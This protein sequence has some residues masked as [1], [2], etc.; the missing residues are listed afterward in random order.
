M[1]LTTSITSAGLTA[2]TPSE[3][4]ADILARAQALSSGLTAN[5]PASLIEDVLATVTGACSIL[6]Q[7]RQDV[8]ASV[9][10]YSV[11][12]YLINQL[13]AQFGI[14]RGIA[15]RA[16]VFVEFTGVAGYVI[17]K[18]FAVSDG[19]YR[20]LVQT[21]AVIPSGG[22]VSLF[23]VA[24]IDGTWA[25]PANTVNQ[26]TTSVPSSIPLTCNNPQA[27][28]PMGTPETEEA[29]RARIIMASA[30][31]SMGATTYLKRLVQNV[32]GV[33]AR[34]VSTPIVNGVAKVIVGGNGD[35]FAIGYAIFSA[36][37]DIREFA[38]ST[39]PSRNITVQIFD[40]PDTYPVSFIVPVR[41]N[42]AVSV[43]WNTTALFTADATLS[44]VAASSII[45][46]IN[47]LPVGYAINLSSLRSEFATAVSSLIDT[48]F[49]S[50]MDFSITLNGTP[51]LPDA[52]STLIHG[53][54]E[55]YFSTDA[56]MITIARG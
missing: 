4:R 18:G 47:N 37:F 50:K 34:L 1:A 39:T 9:S 10:P 8:I 3:V 25:I 2:R 35:P 33:E 42:I 46:Y 11:N 56:S 38:Q 12:S 21:G 54:S 51:L 5:L 41:Q 29:Y 45:N 53:D 48:Q 30:A 27:G 19:S 44:T 43:L 16:S 7:A 17:P 49:L 23:C 28:T 14:V 26:I 40:F 15:S 55:G 52:G 6:E 31:P 32:A 24:T 13:G 20:Y 36:M 22:V